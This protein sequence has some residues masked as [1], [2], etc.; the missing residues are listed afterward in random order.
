M[1]RI[2]ANNTIKHVELL[3][4][5]LKA[6]YEVVLNICDPLLEDQVWHNEDYEEID[7]KQDNRSTE[8]HKKGHVQIERMTHTWDII[9]WRLLPITIN[10]K[11]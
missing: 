7:Y 5:N 1:W 3:E 8:S 6:F 11:K 4:A 10:H 2:R 9:V